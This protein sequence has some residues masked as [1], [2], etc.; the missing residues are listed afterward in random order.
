[1]PSLHVTQM[2]TL[3]KDG[4]AWKPGWINDEVRPSNSAAS[5]QLW[6]LYAI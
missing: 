4:K 6:L 2:M 3:V 1:M 5:L